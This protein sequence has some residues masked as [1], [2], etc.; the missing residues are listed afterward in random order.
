MV[1]KFAILNFPK[2]MIEKPV[3]SRVIRDYDVEVNILQ[4]K[5]T[6]EE[7]GRMFVIFSGG[8][9]A[10]EQSL[11]YLRESGV[12]VILPTQNLVWDESRCVSCSACVGQ[13]ISNAFTVDPQTHRVTYES[14]RCIACELCIPACFYKAIASV[15]D[16]FK[17]NGV[18]Q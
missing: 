13:C 10:V 4:A 17:K 9:D 2:S 3:I 15:G 6:P 18:V 5:I 8:P 14:E 7:D 11:G 16:H 1:Q 12:Q